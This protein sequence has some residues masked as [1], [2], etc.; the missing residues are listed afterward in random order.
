MSRLR[1]YLRQQVL[2]RV[3]I[4]FY[5]PTEDRRILE[6]V[7]F[8]YLLARSDLNRILFVGCEIYT[9]GY[10]RLF[11]ERD[12][13]TIDVNPEHRKYGGRKHITGSFERIG[14]HY[15]PAT[16]DV[17]VCNGVCGWG[18][19]ERHSV[20]AAIAG[21]FSALR[22]GG[23]FVLGWNDTPQHRPFDFRT[24]PSLTLFSAFCFPPLDSAEYLTATSSRHTYNFFE[25]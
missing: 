11:R 22:P 6:K 4:D 17:V 23:L 8:P 2:P 14:Q 24:S 19:D 9:R 25:K 1:D 3:G 7:I 5:L 16:L 20:D 21:T 18:L 12:Y 13:Q 15:G 10:R